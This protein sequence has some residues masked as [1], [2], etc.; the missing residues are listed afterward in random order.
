[1]SANS[2]LTMEYEDARNYIITH[3]ENILEKAKVSGYICP[4]CGSGSGKHGTGIQKSKRNLGHFTCWAGDCFHNATI[5]DIVAKSQHISPRDAFFYCL[6]A[7]HIQLS[8]SNHEAKEHLVMTHPVRKEKEDS[9][10]E[11][12]EVSIETIRQDI[13]KSHEYSP[14]K[15]DYLES[16]GISRAVQ[17]HFGVGYCERWMTPSVRDLKRS[18]GKPLVYGAPY[19]IIPTNKDGSSYLARDTRNPEE[20]T[21]KQRNFCKMKVGNC[22]QFGWDCLEKARG[23]V[24]ITEGEIDAMSVYQAGQTQVLAIGSTAYVSKF[25]DYM[26]K[27]QG[28]LPV[29]FGLLLDH[30]EPGRK[31]SAKLSAGLSKLNYHACD[32]SDILQQ[33]KDANEALC[34]DPK[35]FAMLLRFKANILQRVNQCV[36][37]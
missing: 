20:L 22:H 24:F 28:Q 7:N 25:L 17:D 16:R 21:E 9:V 15:Y 33:A 18:D 34:A 35:R 5:I 1:M 8:H 37:R 14:L 11:K 30:D 36:S 31:A 3:P 27:Q 19:C 10:A 12:P 4:C 6:D 2:L 23:T 29:S 26:S 32:V 13:E